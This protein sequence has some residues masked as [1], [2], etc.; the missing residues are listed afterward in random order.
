MSHGEMHDPIERIREFAISENAGA[1]GW[2]VQAEN[3]NAHARHYGKG[4][5]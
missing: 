2:V 1:G 4:L 3:Q 5:R